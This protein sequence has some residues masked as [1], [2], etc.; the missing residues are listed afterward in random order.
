MDLL[1]SQKIWQGIKFSNLPL[2]PPNFAN[3]PQSLI[4]VNIS[5]YTVL[6]TL[7][8]YAC[9]VKLMMPSNYPQIEQGHDID[10]LAT[11]R[12]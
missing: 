5:G 4:P 10:R 8:V 3:Q 11:V 9:S 1:Y 12:L 2:Q 7:R 6:L